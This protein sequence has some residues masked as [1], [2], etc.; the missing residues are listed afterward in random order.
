[1][2]EPQSVNFDAR[3]IYRRQGAEAERE[4]IIK[5]LE[6]YSD[7]KLLVIPTRQISRLIKGETE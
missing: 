1:M 7:G 2:I 5:L 3:Y 4:R 6:G